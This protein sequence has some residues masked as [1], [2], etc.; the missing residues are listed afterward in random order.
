MDATIATGDHPTDTVFSA[1][2]RT[3]FV[4]NSNRYAVSVL[5]LATE[6]ERETISMGLTPRSPQGAVP[7]GSR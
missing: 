6:R 4:V 2:G 5:D 3:L 1:D 7:W